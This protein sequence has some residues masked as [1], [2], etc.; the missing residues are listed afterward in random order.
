MAL[1]F[2]DPW[3]W[4]WGVAIVMGIWWILR[5]LST[6][7]YQTNKSHGRE[8]C[9][10]CDATR[11]EC[12]CAEFTEPDPIA[13]QEDSHE[14]EDIRPRTGHLYLSEHISDDPSDD[15]DEDDED[16]EDD[17]EDDDDAEEEEERGTYL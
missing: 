1:D 11:K 7:S 2:T 14:E 9:G 4:Y 17:D 10:M 6:I 5:I 8:R 16:D 15:D 13:E 12:E 3:V